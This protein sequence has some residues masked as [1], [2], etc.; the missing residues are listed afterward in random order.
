[1]GRTR[2]A[3]LGAL[4]TAVLAGFA[5]PAPAGAA[6]GMSPGYDV[7]YP[8]CGAALPVGAAFGVVGVDGG[9]ANNAN[10]CLAGQLAWAAATPGL[11]SPVQPPVS[12]Y[13]NTADPGNGVPDWPTPATG[14][15]SATTPYGAC[16]GT[17]SPACGY[18]YGAVR[19]AYSYALAASSGSSVSP[20]GVPWWLDVETVSSWATPAALPGWAQANIATIQGFVAGLRIAGAGGPIGFYSTRAQWLAITGLDATA[21][22]RRFPADLSDWVAGT[23]APSDAQ[24]HCQDTFSGGQVLLTQYAAVGFDGDR[25]CPRAVDARLR[26]ASHLLRAGALRLAWTIAPAY[27]G[28]LTVTLTATRG[29]RP[30]RLSRSVGAAGG[31]WTAVLVLP[32]HAVLRGGRV[33]VTSTGRDGLLAGARRLPLRLSA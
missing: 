13:L 26:I 12:L 30:Y 17:W 25:A 14:S 31:R 4:L 18:L 8:L 28:R 32:R 3:W 5:V 7:S 6:A 22:A 33:V 16:D 2:R 29:G 11:G 27:R 9:L 24:A 15:E 23:G 19:A 1:M 20:A 10:P 21:S